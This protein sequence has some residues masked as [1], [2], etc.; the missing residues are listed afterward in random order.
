MWSAHTDRHRSAVQWGLGTCQ[1]ES[2]P[3]LRNMS[4]T[5]LP[6][7]TLRL[8]GLARHML[9]EY[10]PGLD[11][12]NT[13]TLPYQPQ[14]HGSMPSPRTSLHARAVRVNLSAQ[15]GVG[16]WTTPGTARQREGGAPTPHWLCGLLPARQTTM[17]SCIC[18]HTS[19]HFSKPQSM[20][21][22]K[23]WARAGVRCGRTCLRGCDGGHTEAD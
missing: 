19:L 22:L 17:A 2:Q 16:T 3:E 5:S 14:Q 23:A 10:Q 13:H 6:F 11:L 8:M 12:S 15:H 1:P 21:M 18:I 20:H 9:H 7:A 4:P